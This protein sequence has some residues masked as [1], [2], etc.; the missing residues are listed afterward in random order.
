MRC[1]YLSDLHL[2]AQ[3]FPYSLPRGDVLIVAGDLCHA[4]A[5]DPKRSDLYALRQRDRVQRFIDSAVSSFSH[6]LLIAGN[7]DHYDGLFEETVPLL[8]RHLPA[9]KV[10]DDEVVEIEG[11]R[12]FGGTLWTDLGGS[13][14]EAADQIRRGT[15]EYFF[16]KTRRIEPD[17]H[18]RAI[19]IRPADTLSAHRRSLS[20]L[21]TASSEA[22]PD[23]IITHHAPSH[24]GLNPKHRGSALDAAYASDLDALIEE[25]AVTFWVHGH[26]HI[27][28]RYAIAGTTLLANCR[29]YEGNDQS[30]QIFSVAASFEV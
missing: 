12:F 27:R 20:R 11:I 2:E 24:Q 1:H 9:V 5:L 8:R 19:R 25:L 6:V 13:D 28:R 10:L 22:R 26:T 18:E 30:A 17:G 4:S 7:H 23:V 16:T 14:P 21:R 15:G 29:G 3:D